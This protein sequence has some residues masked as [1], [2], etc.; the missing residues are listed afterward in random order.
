M[1][2]V[3]AGYF[4]VPSVWDDLRA[5]PWAAHPSSALLLQ[6]PVSPHWLQ[7]ETGVAP[8]RCPVQNVQQLLLCFLVH[9]SVRKRGIQEPDLH[10]CCCTAGSLNHG[11]LQWQWPK[12]GRLSDLPCFGS[13]QSTGLLV[14][15][16]PAFLWECFPGC[17]VLLLLGRDGFIRISCQ[18]TPLC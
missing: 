2:P 3:Q 6:A 10:Y 12:F 14:T 18:D 16:K 9:H 11:V 8:S 15:L 4:S 13:S 5:S 1:S 17:S 7:A